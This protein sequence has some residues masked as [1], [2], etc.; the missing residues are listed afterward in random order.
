[1]VGILLFP[2]QGVQAGSLVGEAGS[3]MPHSP[4]KQKIDFKESCEFN[5]LVQIQKLLA[6]GFKI[7]KWNF[8]PVYRQRLRTFF[9]LRLTLPSY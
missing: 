1:M 2:L 5:S 6:L 8:I 4:K 9:R 7:I 3:C